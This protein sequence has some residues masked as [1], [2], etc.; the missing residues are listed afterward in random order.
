MDRHGLKPLNGKSCLSIASCDRRKV[1]DVADMADK[2]LVKLTF[3][4]ADVFDN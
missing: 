2:V 4:Q 3:W 1:S